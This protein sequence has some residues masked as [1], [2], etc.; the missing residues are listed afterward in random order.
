[1][2]IL[3][4]PIITE[5]VTQ[6]NFHLTV[7]ACVCHRWQQFRSVHSLFIHCYKICISGW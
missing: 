1:V 7:C 3:E 6:C 4:H 5:S 2:T